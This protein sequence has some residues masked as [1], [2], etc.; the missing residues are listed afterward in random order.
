MATLSSATLKLWIYDGILGQYNPTSPN[1]TITKTKLSSE[2]TILFEIGELVKDYIPIE[3][4]GNYGTANLT[5]W[6]SYEVTNTFSDNSTSIQKGN[7]LGTHGYGYFED[8][9]NP[10]LNGALQQSNTCI[11]WKEGEKVRVPLY[12]GFELYDVEWYQ[13]GTVVDAQTFGTNLISIT[14]DSDK[15]KADNIGILTADA[16]HIGN[17]Q[18]SAYDISVYSPLGADKAII[19]TR[20]NTQIELSVTYIDECRNTPYKVTFL[21]KFGSLQDIWFFGRRKENANI[22]RES[23]RINTVEST[24]TTKFYST[25]KPTDKIHNV[26]S[27]KSLILNTGFLCSDY[28]EVIQQLMQSTNVWIHENNKVYPV[29]PTDNT[30]D[31]KDERYDKLLNFT[32]KFDYAYSEINLV[33]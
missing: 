2:E 29:I 12:S 7:L 22:T 32:V 30:I 28:N 14:A 8:Q 26:D 9:I 20:D 3:F 33:R 25:Y 19:T 10:Q 18:E 17:V 16:T 4:D 23:F 13:G 27:K 5:A 31:Y 24:A 1:Y 6:V 21:N 11:Y 15:Y